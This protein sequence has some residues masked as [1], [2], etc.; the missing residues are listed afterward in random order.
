MAIYDA[1]YRRMAKAANQ[2]LVTFERAGMY[3]PAVLRVKAQLSMAGRR[4]FSETGK[5]EDQATIDAWKR[6]LRKF[7]YEDKTSTKKGYRQY[8]EEVL[9]KSQELYDY[10][11]A[12]LSDDEWMEIWKSLPDIKTKRNFGSDVYIAIVEEAMEK[13]GKKGKNGK[14]DIAKL[15]SDF[16]AMQDYSKGLKAIGLSKRNVTR[17]LRQFA[18]ARS[19]Q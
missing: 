7:L 8:R 19:D 3:S 4:R 14:L 6:D 13:K 1:E 17:R 15:V 16:E 11:G 9:T 10:R 2:R 5:A 12:G 18:E